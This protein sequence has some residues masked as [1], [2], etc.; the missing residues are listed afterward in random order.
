MEL[1]ILGLAMKFWQWSVLIILIILGFIANL[2]D[3]FEGNKIDFEYD[4]YPHMQPLRIGTAGKGF[5]G[6]I[7]MWLLGVRKWRI[8]QNFNYKKQY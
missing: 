1:D 2:F 6:A 3:K 7:L 5:W 8:T 4:Q